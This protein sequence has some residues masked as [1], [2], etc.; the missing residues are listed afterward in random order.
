M[1]GGYFQQD[2]D[3]AVE[4]QRSLSGLEEDG[5]DVVLIAYAHCSCLSQAECKKDTG[6]QTLVSGHIVG[7][8]TSAAFP[9][10]QLRASLGQ[11]GELATEM[12]VRVSMIHR[13]RSACDALLVRA[14]LHAL[15]FA[16]QLLS[17][18]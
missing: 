15:W 8:E 9:L 18:Y 17:T 1:Q 3:V 11:A 12:Q 6:S 5:R 7:W 2:A 13:C 4:S 16:D 14:S 10:A